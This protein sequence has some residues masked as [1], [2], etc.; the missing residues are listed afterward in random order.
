MSD[1]FREGDETDSE[2]TSKYEKLK[3]VTPLE[4]IG[5]LMSILVCQWNYSTKEA[6]Q[7]VKQILIDKKNKIDVQNL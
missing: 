7:S 2:W 1:V 3:T 6:A 5:E 4:D